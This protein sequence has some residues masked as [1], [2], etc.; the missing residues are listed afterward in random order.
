MQ[1][2]IENSTVGMA[3]VLSFHNDNTEPVLP[4]QKNK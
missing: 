2:S 4:K 1:Q 3:E